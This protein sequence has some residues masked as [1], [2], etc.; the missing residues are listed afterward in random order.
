ML[1]V[2]SFDFVG[3][4][5]GLSEDPPPS[6]TETCGPLPLFSSCVFST[7]LLSFLSNLL[8]DP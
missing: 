6:P 3:T 8:Q 5:E 2:K 4:F 1:F 7:F